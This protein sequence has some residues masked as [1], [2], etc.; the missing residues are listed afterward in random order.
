MR[1]EQRSRCVGRVEHGVSTAGLKMSSL[2]VGWEVQG[3]L[4]NVEPKPRLE[5]KRS[6]LPRGGKDMGAQIGA[7]LRA[8]F[9]PAP[10]GRFS[11]ADDVLSQLDGWATES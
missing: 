9:A 4:E 11:G 10:E 3:S 7:E 1:L 8:V 2:D 6:E 5:R